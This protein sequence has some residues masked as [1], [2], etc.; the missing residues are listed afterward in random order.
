MLTGLMAATTLPNSLQAKSTI[1]DQAAFMKALEEKPW[2]LGYLGTRKAE[3]RATLNSVSGRLP[4]DL[5]GSFYR[6]GP[7]LHNIGADRFK[8]WFDAPGM[9]QQFTFANRKVTHLGRLVETSRN[10]TEFNADEI[11]FSAYGTHS[12]NLKSGLSADAQNTGNISLVQHAGELLALW[13]G[14][15]AHIIDPKSL[16]TLGRKDWSP[17]TTGLPFG[18]HPKIDQDGSMWNIGYSTDPA[19]LILYHIA[20]NGQLLKAQI[21]PQTVTPMIHDFMITASKIVI[22]APPYEASHKVR[23]PFID[24]FEWKPSQP[25]RILVIEKDS[26]GD[27]S[28]IDTDPFWVFH[29]GNAYDLSATEIGFDFVRHDNPN[30]NIKDA[31][32]A[33]D[34]SWDGAGS[35]ASNYVQAKLDLVK[36]TALLEKSSAFGQ[37]EFIQT[38]SRKN[39]QP[40]RFTLMICQPEGLDVF[41]YNRLLLIDRHSGNTSHFDVGSTEILEEHLIVPKPNREEAFWIIGT[42]LDWQV[43]V[44]NLSVYEGANLADGP[45]F[46][47]ALDLALPLG[48][49]GT[50]TP[51][52]SV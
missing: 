47:A 29:F 17:E 45:I 26:L 7:A 44:T 37:V 9:I 12:H 27:V 18:A 5:E 34:G 23:A 41:G 1:G 10:I 8:H 2:L 40:H 6:N 30:F 21:L 11:V 50:F 43:G 22:V 28:I 19:V 13:E 35:S 24:K 46:K 36:K 15:S 52:G 33:M 51:Y 42:A 16:E 14:G 25:T 49:H 38:D 48:L 31:F 3:L 32:V 4:N 20:A 39:R